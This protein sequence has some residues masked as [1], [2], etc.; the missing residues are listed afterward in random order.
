MNSCPVL[1]IGGATRT[2]QW[3]PATPRSWTV[4]ARDFGSRKLSGV[5]VDVVIDRIDEIVAYMDR[6]VP[7]VAFAEGAA[8]TGPAVHRGVSFQ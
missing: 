4:D 8:A 2:A 6:L 1:T 7:P 3:R 5:P